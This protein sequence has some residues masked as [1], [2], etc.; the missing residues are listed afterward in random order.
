MGYDFLKFQAPPHGLLTIAAS[1]EKAGFKIK[2]I[3]QRV[4]NDFKEK[5][6]EE[7]KNC[8]FIGISSMT[9][10]Q[11]EFAIEISKIIKK[12]SPKIP[13]IWGGIHPT[14]LPKETLK[15]EFIDFIIIG[16]GEKAFVQLAKAIKQKN[17]YKHIKNLGFKKNKRI[18]IN[19]KNKFINLNELPL[20]PWHLLNVEK[21]V[22]KYKKNE[23]N[24]RELDLGTTSRGCPAACHFC[25]NLA[26]NKRQWRS[27]SAKKVFYMIIKVVN[28][29]KI[30]KIIFRDDDFFADLKRVEEICKL[31]IKNNLDIEWYSAGIRIETFNIM[32]DFLIKL[33]KK[34]G[35][36]SFRFGVESGSPR[37]LKYIN[38]K[39]KPTEIIEANK[40]CMQHKIIPHYSF[41]IG[42]PTEKIKDMM[43]TVDL[44]NK[45]KKDNP[46]AVIH[47]VNI[48]TP[49]PGTALFN[50]MKKEGMNIPTKTNEWI[51]FHHLNLV[52]P[53]IRKKEQKMIKTINELSYMMSDIA[54][55][56]LP[57]V[58]K[59]ISYPIKKWCGFRWKNKLFR[60]TP[61]LLILKKIREKTLGI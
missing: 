44:I 12:N 29:Y 23:K 25:Y 31:I 9:G 54:Y 15:N 26:I 19:K 8:L 16:E 34:S 32:K 1:L 14:I 45:L 56:N 13:L 21:Y 4:E 27:L 24:I 33:I 55:D 35:C 48:L 58:L 40:K 30:N 49:Y 5:L 28:D 37:I 53:K 47:C 50:I 61:E 20:T 18:I 60:F 57:Y 11:L 10:K 46:S 43:M 22:F 36:S 41:M 2:I 7:I 52:T 6:L 39:I 3:D 38:K 17:N 59:T 42:F 51:K